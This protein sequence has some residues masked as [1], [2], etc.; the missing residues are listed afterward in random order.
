MYLIAVERWKAKLAAE[1]K[2][3]KMEFSI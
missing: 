1:E 2:K 3:E